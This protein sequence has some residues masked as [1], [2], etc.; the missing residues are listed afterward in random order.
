MAKGSGGTGKGKR[1]GAAASVGGSAK[2]AAP[3]AAAAP[4][5]DSVLAAAKAL[6]DRAGRVDLLALRPKL[7]GTK[8]QQ[9][10][11]LLGLMDAGKGVLMQNDHLGSLQRNS[12]AQYAAHRAAAVVVG[13]GRERHLLMLDRSVR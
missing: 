11:A 13:G 8:E 4:T 7:G 2:P 1:G 5:V 3:A 10:K 6:A 9:D 12:P